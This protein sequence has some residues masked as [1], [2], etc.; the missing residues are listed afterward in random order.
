MSLVEVNSDGGELALRKTLPRTDLATSLRRAKPRTTSSTYHPVTMLAGVG[1]SWSLTATFALWGL[2]TT[3]YT[4]PT[5]ADRCE[6]RSAQ[7]ILPLPCIT[8]IGGQSGTYRGFA[9]LI[10]R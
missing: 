7:T 3:S 5:Y 6:L 1:S 4:P 2:F 10:S 9:C 8:V